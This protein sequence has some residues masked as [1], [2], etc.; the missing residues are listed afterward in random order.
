MSSLDNL[1]LRLG[2][3]GGNAEGRMVEGKLR[4]LKKALLYSYQSATIVVADRDNPE[5]YTNKFRCLINP[6]KLKNDYDNKILSIPYEDIQ[7]NHPID[8]KTTEGLIANGLQSGDTFYWEETDTYWIIY[9]HHK[10]EKAYFRA[11]IRE[12]KKEIEINGRKYKIYFRSPEET[13]IPWNQKRGILWNTI[14]YSSLIYVTKNKDTLD[15]FHRFK[16]IKIDGK[17]WR[18]EVVRESAGDG[19]LEIQLGEYYQ[20]TFQDI[21]DNQIESEEIIDTEVP[22]IIGNKTIYP[23]DIVQYSITNFGGGKWYIDSPKVKIIGSSETSVTIEVISGTSGWFNLQYIKDEEV[24]AEA[25]I[26]I[27][28]L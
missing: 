27:A 28:S 17:N 10:E 12:C 13:T 24:I 26:T 25:H 20:N 15:F 11:E 6:D 8:G 14:N 21:I 5:N 4:S 2:Y 16:I 9:L 3:A 19:V 7:L 18:V 23:Y 22:Y 1:N